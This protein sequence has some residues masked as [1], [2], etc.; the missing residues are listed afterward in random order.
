MSVEIMTIQDVAK[1]L[2][3]NEATIY[4]YIQEGKLPAARMG[5][6]YRVRREDVDKFFDA[7]K[8]AA[9]DRVCQAGR[10]LSARTGWKPEMVDQAISEYRRSRQVSPKRDNS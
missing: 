6:N 1:Y 8:V 10:E 5:R 7:R 2:R 4:R 9:W 3:M